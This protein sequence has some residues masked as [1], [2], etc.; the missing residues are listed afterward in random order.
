[1]CHLRLRLLLLVLLSL[2]HH[3][4]SFVP[5]LSLLVYERASYVSHVISNVMLF[6]L[7]TTQGEH[8]ER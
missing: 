1:M 6:T 8:H 5:L 3:S 2:N 4:V 7:P